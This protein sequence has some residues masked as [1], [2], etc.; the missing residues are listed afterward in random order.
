MRKTFNGEQKEKSNEIN[1]LTLLKAFEKL[2]GAQS[3]VLRLMV[4][5]KT[6]S[7]ISTLLHIS[8]K[9]VSNHI[10]A[11]GEKLNLQ[12]RGKVRGW[13]KF[14]TKENGANS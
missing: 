7:E 12:G 3:R 9:T 8:D 6:N 2:S 4:E 1:S 5:G 14:I 13:L 10:T 11:I